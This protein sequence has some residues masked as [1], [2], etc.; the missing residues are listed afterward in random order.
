MSNTNTPSN[1]NGTAASNGQATAPAPRKAAF[2]KASQQDLAGLIQQTETL[3][4]ALRAH[5]LKTNELL[6]R[7]K[8]H[9]RQN[10]A[11]R[12]TIDSLRQLKTLGV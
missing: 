8:H 12:Q 4:T 9:R 11:L 6:R 1:G 3:R 10:R 7:L 2:R 5:L